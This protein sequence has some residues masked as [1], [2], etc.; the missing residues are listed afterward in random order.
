LP[1]WISDRSNLGIGQ[2]HAIAS[3]QKRTN[4]IGLIVID[5]IGLVKTAGTKHSNRTLE[6]G[7]V[8]R[9][10]KAMAKDLDVPVIVLAQLNREIDKTEREPRLSDLRDSGEIEQDADVVMFVTRT[11]DEGVTKVTVAKHRHSSTG[12]CRLMHRGD[13]S[14]FDSM[15]S[16]YTAP[17]PTKNNLSRF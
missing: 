10:C 6:L 17:Q 12:D 1:V 16:G 11:Q 15:Q 9:Q 4:K 13:L 2:I 8:S 14:R 3:F 7:E 5:Y